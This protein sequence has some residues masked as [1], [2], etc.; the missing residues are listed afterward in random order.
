MSAIST[1]TTSAMP[2]TYWHWRGQA[3]YY[4]RAGVADPQ[5]SPL[6]LVHGFGAST[7]HWRKNIAE[8]SNDFE[9][10]AIDLLGFGRSAKPNMQYSGDLWRDQLHEF[11][12]EV[13]GRPVV[14]VGNSLGGYAAL[15]VA[16]QHPDSA[17]GLVLINSAGPFTELN[18]PATT[19]TLPV[20]RVLG[21]SV[22]W[23]LRQP[24][25]SFILFQ[26]FRQRSVIRQTLEKVYLDKN[27]ITDQLVED[28]YRPSCDPGAPQVFASVFSS[29]Q[30]EK[31]DVLLEQL[32]RPL[33]MIWGEGDPWMDIQKRAA[34]FRKHYPQLTEH[35]LRAGHCPHD[36]V[37]DQFNTLVRSWML[38][39]SN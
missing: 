19:Q 39:I 15:C 7:D 20:Q 37:P 25:A 12:T 17:V 35:Y 2:G 31:V 1:L 14:L 27:A 26:Y 11:V 21:E 4:V 10:W 9:V 36:E 8:L 22:R 28:I 30:G 3:I 13:I 33:L 32:N 24:W 5:R 34:Q 29:P 18:A 16:S 6:L 23:V 38:S